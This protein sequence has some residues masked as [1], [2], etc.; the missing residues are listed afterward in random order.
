MRRSRDQ[1]C[2]LECTGLQIVGSLGGHGQLRGII[3]PYYQARFKENRELQVSL[4]WSRGAGINLGI[5]QQLHML[6]I[7]GKEQ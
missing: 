4:F 7:N 6:V 1:T 2:S 5:I 3:E